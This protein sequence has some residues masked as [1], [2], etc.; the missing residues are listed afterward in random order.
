M[1]IQTNLIAGRRNSVESRYVH[2]ETM[3]STRSDVRIHIYIYVCNS[4]YI[5]TTADGSTK[6][7]AMWELFK[8]GKKRG[9]TGNSESETHGRVWDKF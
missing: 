1:Q 9:G 7:T 6:G 5:N 4:R 3:S 8:N 2:A